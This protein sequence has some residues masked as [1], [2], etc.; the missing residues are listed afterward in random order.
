MSRKEEFYI[1]ISLLIAILGCIAA[2]IALP[3]VQHIIS[4][5]FSR[6]EANAKSSQ[7]PPT[8][9]PTNPKT[10]PNSVNAIYT[11]TAAAQTVETRL[12]ENAPAIF[13]NTPTVLVTQGKNVDP[14]PVMHS[15]GDSTTFSF[16]VGS[17]AVDIILNIPSSSMIFLKSYDT[18]NVSDYTQIREGF[19]PDKKL[20]IIEQSNKYDVYE[21]NT[22][23]NISVSVNSS[24]S[25]SVQAK[26]NVFGDGDVFI[27]IQ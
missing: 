11:A 23:S 24:G 25:S 26:T 7:I 17:T 13:T 18:N 6:P 21:L 22:N 9:I 10:G 4:G 14:T 5:D 12:T 20:L 8:D 2:W 15:Q 19:Y 27:F 3:Q 1:I 16:I